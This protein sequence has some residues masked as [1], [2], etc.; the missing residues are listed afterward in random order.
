MGRDTRAATTTRIGTT[1]V[2]RDSRDALVAFCALGSM[3]IGGGAAWGI[4]GF[5]FGGG[6]FLMFSLLE[7]AIEKNAGR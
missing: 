4:G 6:L 3:L 2:A 7:R 1:E 5:I